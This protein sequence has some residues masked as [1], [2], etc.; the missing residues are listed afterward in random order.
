[1]NPFVNS[2]RILNLLSICQRYKKLPSEVMHVEDGY[3]AYCLD[4]ACSYISSRLDGGEEL[5]F[6][7]KYTSFSDMYAKY[8]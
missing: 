2:P 5:S 7:T 3:T 1:M 6:K 8:E 4:E